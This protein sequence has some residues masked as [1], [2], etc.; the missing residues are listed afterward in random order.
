MNKEKIQGKI[1]GYYYSEIGGDGF[2]TFVVKFYNKNTK[3]ENYVLSN[4]YNNDTY[5][6]NNLSN[7][8]VTVQFDKK[9][10]AKVG[11]IDFSK[12]ANSKYNLK[13]MTKSEYYKL[14]VDNNPLTKDQKNKLYRKN[15]KENNTF[16]LGVALLSLFVPTGIY[17]LNYYE[18]NSHSLFLLC[19][20]FW[21][22][23]LVLIYKSLSRRKYGISNTKAQMISIEVIDKF[24][25]LDRNVVIFKTLD[26]INIKHYV[27]FTDS[28]LFKIGEVYTINIKKYKR[29]IV[30]PYLEFK[31]YS[32]IELY[33]FN[34]N[35]FFN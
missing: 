12:T 24:S 25:E 18:N 33:G 26:K 27:Y 20:P 22:I 13:R 5:F 3:T 1:I 19:L 14:V 34:D 30:V 32:C 8:L 29:P 7:D 35:D 2:I 21:L 28:D 9:G 31:G 15:S 23:S 4:S 10:N 11:K 6:I 16:P 17:I